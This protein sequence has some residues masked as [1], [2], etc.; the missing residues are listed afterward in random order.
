MGELKRQSA[1]RSAPGGL[2]QLSI[3]PVSTGFL[4]TR[5]DPQLRR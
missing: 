5:D 4:T 3:V 1:G 2:K